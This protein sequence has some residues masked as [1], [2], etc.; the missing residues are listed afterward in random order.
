MSSS[1]AQALLNDYFSG[2]EVRETSTILL[3]D[4]VILITLKYICKCCIDGL[5]FNL[6]G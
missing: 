3:V 5:E 4:E 6:L 2:K 1:K